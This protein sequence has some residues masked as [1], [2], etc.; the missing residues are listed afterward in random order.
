MLHKPP[1]W[2]WMKYITSQTSALAPFFTTAELHLCHP[3]VEWQMGGL[4]SQGREKLEAMNAS[5][6]DV[7]CQHLKPL[8]SPLFSFHFKGCFTGAT[9]P[10]PLL[11]CKVSPA[12]SPILCI[13]APFYQQVFP[14][15]FR[16]PTGVQTDRTFQQ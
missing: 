8:H 3:L 4:K 14:G 12:S 13:H 6:F 7:E 9:Q 16:N 1:Q 5:G 2:I 11:R 10:V 15:R